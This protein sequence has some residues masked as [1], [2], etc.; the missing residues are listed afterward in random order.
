MFLACLDTVRQIKDDNWDGVVVD[1]SSN[2][3]VEHKSQ[4]RVVVTKQ[5]CISFEPEVTKQPYILVEP[6]VFILS[7]CTFCPL[8]MFSFLQRSSSS[9]PMLDKNGPVQL[10]FASASGNMMLQVALKRVS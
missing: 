2:Q 1:I 6:E 8:R 5:P 7:K 9:A 4:V 3:E 10:H